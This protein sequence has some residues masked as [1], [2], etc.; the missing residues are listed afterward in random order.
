MANPT[1]TGQPLFTVP[2]E[3]QGAI[4]ATEPAPKIYLLS[5]YSPPDNRLTPTFDTALLTALDIL[6]QKYP[7]GVVV[8][9]SSIQKFYS[10]GLDLDLVGK[11]DNFFARFMY[12]L[13]RRLLR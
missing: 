10:N 1:P 13:W 4:V 7:R 8:T 9:T 3:P 11:T 12:P 5:F 6:E 2:I